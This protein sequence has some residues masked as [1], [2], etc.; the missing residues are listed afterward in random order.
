MI[1][2]PAVNIIFCDSTSIL[3]LNSVFW[4]MSLWRNTDNAQNLSFIILVFNVQNLITHQ[5]KSDI[6]VQ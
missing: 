4:K 6:G 2:V 5:L 1:S 3:K